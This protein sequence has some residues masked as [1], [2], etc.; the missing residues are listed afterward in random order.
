MRMNFP[1]SEVKVTPTRSG[2]GTLYRVTVRARF[3]NGDGD[4]RLITNG[5]ERCLTIT[6][7]EAEELYL[8]LR[9]LRAEP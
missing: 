8:A 3:T 9:E 6:A 2:F 7:E 4:R 5:I 1:P